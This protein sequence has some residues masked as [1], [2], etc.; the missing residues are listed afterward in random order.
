MPCRSV[1]LENGVRAIVCTGRQPKKRCVEC[2]KPA[3]L[4][5]DWKIKDPRRSTCDAPLCARCTSKPAP[6]KDLCPMHARMWADR[7][8]AARTRSGRAEAG[9]AE[10]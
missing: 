9:R 4:L 8:A 6:D 3:D 2:G 10:P 5:C 7:Q 1:Q